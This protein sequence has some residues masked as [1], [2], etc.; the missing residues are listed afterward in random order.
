MTKIRFRSN[1]VYKNVSIAVRLD[2]ECVLK[3]KKQIVTPGE[4]EEVILLPK[5]LIKAKE[6]SVITLEIEEDK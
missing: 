6:N 2:E 5:N 1:T 4:M 3:K